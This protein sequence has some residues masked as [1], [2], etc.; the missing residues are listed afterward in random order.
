MLTWKP[1]CGTNHGSPQTAENHYERRKQQWESTKATTSCTPSSPHGGYNEG[2]D[3]SLTIHSHMLFTYNA[4]TSTNCFCPKSYLYTYDFRAIYTYGPKG[5]TRTHSHM[6]PFQPAEEGY[7]RAFN[8]PILHT[9]YPEGPVSQQKVYQWAYSRRPTIQTNCLYNFGVDSTS[10]FYRFST[11]YEQAT[12][13][14]EL[15]LCCP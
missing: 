7:H 2:N 8:H 3:L 14:L 15:Q 9:S 4:T 13:S 11:I 5:L 10:I 1:K 12:Y 6:C